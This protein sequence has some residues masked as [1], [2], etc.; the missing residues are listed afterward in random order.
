MTSSTLP[1]SPRVY[2]PAANPVI[3][4]GKKQ[5][6]RRQ[7]PR[8]I[9]GTLTSEGWPDRCPVPSKWTQRTRRGFSVSANSAHL[10]PNQENTRDRGKRRVSLPKEQSVLSKHQRQGTEA[11]EEVLWVTDD[12]GAKATAFPVP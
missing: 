7:G 6:Y 2:L 4:K 10:E 12:Y 11:G 5:I 9:G 3:A 8:T 1:L